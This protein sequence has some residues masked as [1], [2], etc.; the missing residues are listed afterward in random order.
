MRAEL[1]VPGR[2]H[3]HESGASNRRTWSQAIV[4][5][6]ADRANDVFRWFESHVHVGHGGTSVVGGIVLVS[7]ILVV[8]FVA[9]RLLISLQIAHD[10]RYE[11]LALRSSSRSARA[12][13]LGAV[14]AATDADFRS[15][16]RLL[17]AAAVTLLELRGMVS[18]DEGATIN[19]LRRALYDRDASAE[20]AFVEIARA[21]TA[22]A[23]AEQEINAEVWHRAHGAYLI[24]S[25]RVGS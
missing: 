4:E 7:S 11:S 22:V 21:Y 14:R 15:A 5:W 23:Y 10:S 6:L 2:Y 16:V 25:D 3:L 19:E 18:D 17:F 1:A 8:G 24:L 20:G 9:A 12:L 13:A